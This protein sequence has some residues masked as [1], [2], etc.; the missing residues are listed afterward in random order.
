VST[1][2]D[3][4]SMPNK[5]LVGWLLACPQRASFIPIES[6]STNTITLSFE[7][8]DL[9]TNLLLTRRRDAKCQTKP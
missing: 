3:K 6:E 1:D 2:S 7:E 9:P 5:G 8:V 4:D